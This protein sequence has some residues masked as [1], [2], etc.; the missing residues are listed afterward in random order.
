MSTM[1]S[2][3]DDHVESMG[4]IKFYE[5]RVSKSYYLK[6]YNLLYRSVQLEQFLFIYSNYSPIYL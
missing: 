1:G 2:K 4:S 3:T 5:G 6:S